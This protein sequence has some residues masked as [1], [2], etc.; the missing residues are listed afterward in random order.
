MV[1]MSRQMLQQAGVRPASPALVRAFAVIARRRL[2][3]GFRALRMLHAERLAQAGTGPLIVY[4]NHPSW[5]DPLLC[6]TLARTLLPD[7]MHHAP[8]SA[9]SLLR[10]PMFGKLGMFP[11]DQGSARGAAQFLRSS[12]S[13]LAA[14]GVL[15]I[16]AQGRFSDVRLRPTTLKA[17]LGTLL[18]RFHDTTSITVLPLAVEYTFWN[19]VKPEALVAAGTPIPVHRMETTHTARTWTQLLEEHLQTT[20][21]EL[22]VA[23]MDR[24]PAIFQTL[25]D[26]EGASLW[27]RL[28]ARMRGELEMPGAD[29]TTEPH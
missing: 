18:H 27:Q 21:D 20:Q 26:S 14:G 2:R 1:P 5:W 6:L 24:D 15:W 25:L 17:G 19:G 16:T 7:C 3:G 28:R 13:V 9:A 12:Q 8:M 4:L 11:V 10:Y 29:H 22:A 23:A